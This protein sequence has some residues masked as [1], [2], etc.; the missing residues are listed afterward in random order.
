MQHG[1]EEKLSTLYAALLS[2]SHGIL[3]GF[4][5]AFAFAGACLAQVDRSA[6]NGTVTDPTGRVLPGVEVA[7]VQ[8][9]TG[10]RRT[11]VTFWKGDLRDPG[12]AG[13]SLHSDV[14]A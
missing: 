9:S 1:S 2:R 13:G 10:L 6:L 12:V 8:D 5:L 11:T 14:Q 4:C 3:T 7:A